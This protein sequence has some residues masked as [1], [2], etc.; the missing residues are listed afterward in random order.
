MRFQQFGERYIVRIES[1]E[2]VFETLTR[3]LQSEGIEFASISAA[4]AVRDVTLGYWNAATKE[5]HFREFTE[6]AEVVSFAGNA[7]LKDGAPFLHVHGVFG[8]GDF[9]VFGGHVKEATVHPT[10]EIWL[11]TEDVQV[12]RARDEASGLDLLD[13]PERTSLPR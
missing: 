11:R 2:H 8:R 5:Y 12:R 9:S 10:L 3:F 6:Q 1:G 13:L 4:G 7:A